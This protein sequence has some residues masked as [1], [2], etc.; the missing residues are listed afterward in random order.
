[1]VLLVVFSVMHLQCCCSLFSALA[2]S[3][4]YMGIDN[5]LLAFLWPLRHHD[6]HSMGGITH[7]SGPSCGYSVQA[8]MWRGAYSSDMLSGLA[9]GRTRA[10]YRLG[11]PIP[12]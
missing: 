4:G 5:S 7:S 2:V 9:D 3:L 6:R 11:L 12:I 1:M 10:S 8:T